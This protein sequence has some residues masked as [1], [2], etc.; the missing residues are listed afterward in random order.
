VNSPIIE[1][2]LEGSGFGP[3]K[4][5]LPGGTEENSA[6]TLC[7]YCRSPGRDLRPGP[8]EQGTVILTNQ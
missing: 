2:Y 6:E 3:L 4:V 7:Q 5:H 8:T 1:K